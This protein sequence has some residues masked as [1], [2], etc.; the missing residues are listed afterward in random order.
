MSPWRTHLP[1]PLFS[2]QQ[3]LM[4]SCFAAFSD[5]ESL[6]LKIA[7]R[8]VEAS[9]VVTQAWSANTMRLAFKSAS[10]VDHQ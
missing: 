1:T 4:I 2:A 9:N 10:F 7:S 5:S 8:V 3:F 6:S